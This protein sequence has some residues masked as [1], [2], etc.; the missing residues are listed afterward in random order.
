[1]GRPSTPG[2]RAWTRDLRGSV[3]VGNVIDQHQ[4]AERMPVMAPVVA[5]NLPESGMGVMSISIQGR[6]SPLRIVAEA[7][8]APVGVV[9]LM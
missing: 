7:Q 5:T 6:L 1:M 3:V 4:R 8:A 9:C 2:R